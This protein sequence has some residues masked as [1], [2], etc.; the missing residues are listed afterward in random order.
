MI[1]S[2]PDLVLQRIAWV[3]PVSSIF[4]LAHVTK[5]ICVKMASNQADVPRDVLNHVNL[6]P[7]AGAMNQV[8]QYFGFKTEEGK[9]LEPS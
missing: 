9:V 8:Q 6:V 1:V 3:S 5:Y 2:I 4:N 7:L